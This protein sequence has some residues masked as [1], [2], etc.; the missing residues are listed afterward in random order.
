MCALRKGKDGKTELLK[1]A[2][3]TIEAAKTG[4]MEAV[5][6]IGNRL[7]GKAVQQTDL[8]IDATADF[9]GHLAGAWARMKGG[10]NAA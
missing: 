5:K 10:G 1:I 4:D 3:A 8:N 2:E 7:D 6:E 9:V